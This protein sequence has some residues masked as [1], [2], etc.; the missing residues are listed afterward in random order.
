MPDQSTHT[1][2]YSY[3]PDAPQLV[4]A[5]WRARVANAKYNEFSVET[6]LPNE[7]SNARHTLLQKILGQVGD[8]SQV[9]VPFHV[10][11]GCNVSIGKDSV[12]NFK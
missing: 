12:A 11:Y 1:L 7:L 8:R 5:R 3:N 4:E 6:F 10:D 9:E 2:G